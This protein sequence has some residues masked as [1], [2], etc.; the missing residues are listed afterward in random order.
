MNISVHED[1]PGREGPTNAISPEIRYHIIIHSHYDPAWF[2]VREETK[3][4]LKPYFAKIFSLLD[5]YPEYKFVFDC[6]TQVVEDYL[7]NFEAETRKEKEGKLRSFIREG[8]FVVGPYYTGV[9][10]N[11]SGSAVLRKNLLFGTRDARALGWPGKFAGWTIDQFG[12]PAQS[13]QIHKSF[14]INKIVLWRGLGVDPEEVNTEL[15]LVSPDGSRILGKWLFIQGYRFGLYLGK[16]QEIAVRRL[17]QEGRKALPFSM[18]KDVLIMDGYEGEPEPDNPVALVREIVKLGG[19]AAITT[20]LQYLEKIEEEL[21]LDDLPRIEGYQ[22]FGY[23]SPVLKGVFSSRQY[24]KQSHRACDALL[25][26]WLDPFCFIAQSFGIRQNW[27][28]LEGLWRSLIRMAS[29]DEIGGCGIDDVHRESQEVYRRIFRDSQTILMRNLNTITANI[30]TSMGSEE[31]LPFVLFNPLVR[32]RE[33]CASITLQVPEDWKHF[34]VLSD[35]G[36]KIPWQLNSRTADRVELIILTA[37]PVPS[38][39]YKTYYLRKTGRS[40]EAPP[41]DQVTAGKNWMENDQLKITINSDGTFSLFDKALGKEYNGLGYFIVEPDRGDT[42]DYSHIQHCRVFSTRGKEATLSCLSR[43]PLCARF[44]IDHVLELPSEI[45]QDRE[46]WGMETV[47]CPFTITIQ[48]YRGSPR[49]DL[50]LQ[51]A[52][53]G[54]DRRVRICFPADIPTDGLSV[55]RQYDVAKV[56]VNGKYLSPRQKEEIEAKI[57]GM[58][59]VPVRTKVVFHWADLSDNYCGLAF[60]SRDNFE[61]EVSTNRKG[62]KVFQWTLLRSVGWNARADLLTRN[63]NAGWRIYTPDAQCQGNYSFRLSLI[64]HRG[65]WNEAGVDNLAEDRLEDLRVLPAGP[66]CGPLPSSFSFFNMESGDVHVA[67]VTKAQDETG[68]LII[69]L[70]NPSEREAFAT[71]YFRDEL[72]KAQLAGLDEQP[73]QLLGD[74]NQKVLDLCLG[75]KKISTLRLTLRDFFLNAEMPPVWKKKVKNLPGLEEAIGLKMKPM[76]SHEEVESE[77]RRWQKLEAEYRRQRKGLN[78]LKEKTGLTQI[79]DRYRAEEGLVNLANTLKE[80]HYSYLLTL[81]RFYESTGRSDDADRVDEEIRAMARE[82][83]ALRVQKREAEIYSLFY[84]NL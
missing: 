30:N 36:K 64:S 44:R 15:A 17:L 75:P 66:S 52:N 21:Q 80:A 23:Y 79:I 49:V 72:E 51:L 48:I 4:L 5:R 6:Q 13:W 58:D 41:I 10:W 78:S 26:K 81:K 67:E 8:R 37:D 29:H 11:L 25:T 59:L 55:A 83:I 68:D 19:S 45:S 42:Y 76:V 69:V 73:L 1:H 22:D 7:D 61:C 24:L 18:I 60:I 12:F 74:K 63:V 70:Y 50:D 54:K 38:L 35:E 34:K 27:G 2:T 28:K 46:N 57:S 40:V 82:L 77:K 39:G 33:T 20:P 9:D 71:L 32:D 62:G 14:G 53:K 3:R 65:G 47:S 56:P 31:S 43:G 84:E 16:F